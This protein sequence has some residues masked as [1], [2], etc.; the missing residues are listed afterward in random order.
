MTM[1]KKMKI[2][3]YVA[4]AALLAG[5]SYGAFIGT[6][7]SGNWTNTATWFGG[8]VPD[9]DGADT[10]AIRQG[11]IVVVDSAVASSPN[12]INVGN[13][14]LGTLNINAGA[15]ISS[16][17]NTL[18][19]NNAAGVGTLNINAGFYTVGNRLFIGA[20]GGA[21]TVNLDGGELYISTIFTNA[22]TIVGSS[23]LDINDGILKWNADNTGFRSVAQI[24]A[25]EGYVAAGDLTFGG[26]GA[27]DAADDAYIIAANGTSYLYAQLNGTGET[28]VW[29]TVI[30]EPATLGLISACG[31]FVLLS[32][33]V[34][35]M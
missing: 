35:R 24:T 34:F 15:D 27:Y 8:S 33:R 19:G 22:L 13:S 28:E 5:N 32:R 20:N 25:L 31:V 12:Q 14:G 23:T 10:A 7:Q 1:N 3:G 4:V 9:A 17:V 16:A 21:G 18:V 29:S 11:H 30:P 2:A 6:A 26:T